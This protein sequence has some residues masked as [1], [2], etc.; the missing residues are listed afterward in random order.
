MTSPTAVLSTRERLIGAAIALFWEKGYANTS[1]SDLLK[2]GQGEQRKLLS[3]FPEQRGVAVCGIGPV[4][5]AA[6]SGNAG[7]GVGGH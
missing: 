1:M 4:L 7:A 2:R 3:F 5:H 6:A